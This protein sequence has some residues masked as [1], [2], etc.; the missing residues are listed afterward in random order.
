MQLDR[1]RNPYPFTWEIPV[2]AAGVTLLLLILGAHTGRGLALL[3]AGG[4]WQWP[5]S[6]NLLTSL[7][8]ILAGNPAAGLVHVPQATSN[9]AVLAWIIAVELLTVAGLVLL[10]V[11]ALTRWGPSRMRGMATAAEAEA[12]LGVSRLRK[13]RHIIRPD[14]YPAKERR[15]R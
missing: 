3:F 8:G 12:T 13:H 10:A 5:S 4:G 15:S 9:P 14:L 1:R 6:R 2:G 7:P 11:W